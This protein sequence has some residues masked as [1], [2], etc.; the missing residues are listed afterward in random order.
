MTIRRMTASA[1]ALAALTLLSAASHADKIKS[2]T[3]PQ[4]TTQTGTVKG[5]DSPGG[6]S[7]GVKSGSFDPVT[8]TFPKS[9]TS[10]S[11]PNGSTF[12]R[13][14]GGQRR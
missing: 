2:G 4:G 14:G 9:T 3:A 13:G 1:M 5:I 12:N 8:V 7:G 10:R 11:Q 6:Q